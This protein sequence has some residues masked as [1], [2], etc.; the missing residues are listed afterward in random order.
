MKIA[1]FN[2]NS[3]RSRLDIILPWLQAHKP[4]VLGV[5]E[6]KTQDHDFPIEAFERAGW[7]VVFKGEKSY[8][9]VALI[10]K[11]EPQ[12]VKFGF[13]DGGPGDETRLVRAVIN[14]VPVVNTYVPQGRAVDHEMYQYKLEWYGRLK[15]LFEA[16]YT[17]EAPLAWIGDLNVA[18]EPIDVYRPETKG[19]NPCYHVAA[20]NAFR[21]VCDFGLVDLLRQHHKDEA[22]YSYFDYRLPNAVK[23]N[24]GWRIDYVMATPPLAALCRSCRIDLEPRLKHKPS[25]HTFMIADFD[26]PGSGVK[27]GI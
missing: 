10:C 4:D 23:N 3:I 14:G 21:D 2:A 16:E 9:G 15:K 6:T 13:K 24:L 17:P 11:S 18:V 19:N 12:E 1:T 5:Q 7:K 22:V 26:L 20:R 27:K 25:D 8:N